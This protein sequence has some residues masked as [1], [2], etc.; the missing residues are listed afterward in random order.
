MTPDHTAYRVCS[1]GCGRAVF[2]SFFLEGHRIGHYEKAP[3]CCPCSRLAALHGAPL[4]AV[5]HAVSAVWEIL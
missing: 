4:T 1:S 5:L 2:L 3:F